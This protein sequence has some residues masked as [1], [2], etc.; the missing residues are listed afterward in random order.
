VT[1]AFGDMKPLD[2]RI[3]L[4]YRKESEEEN[5][6]CLPDLIHHLSIPL[7]MGGGT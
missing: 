5:D 7:L 1:A 2:E 6:F 3:S 4:A